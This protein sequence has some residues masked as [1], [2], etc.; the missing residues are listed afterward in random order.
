MK[1]PRWSAI[2]AAALGGKTDSKNYRSG[3]GL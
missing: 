1:R 2:A 3:R